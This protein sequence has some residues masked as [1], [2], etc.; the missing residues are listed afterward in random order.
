M[1]VHVC[2]WV[3]GWSVGRYTYIYIYTGAITNKYVAFNHGICQCVCNCD[4]N[5]NGCGVEG[6]NCSHLLEGMSLGMSFD[7]G[8]AIPYQINGAISCGFRLAPAADDKSDQKQR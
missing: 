7:R 3:N 2:A 1:C 6:E 4:L 8:A 5:L